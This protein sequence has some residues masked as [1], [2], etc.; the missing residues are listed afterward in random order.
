MINLSRSKILK[1]AQNFNKPAV[2]FVITKGWYLRLINKKRKGLKFRKLSRSEKSEIKDYWKQYGKNISTDWCAYFS[3]GSRIVDKRYIPESLYYGEIIRKINDQGMGGLSDKNVYDMIFDTLQ[4]RTI[5]RKVNGILLNDIREPISFE[6][7]LELCSTKRNV[8]IKPSKG[9]Y[10]G[11]GINFWS[12]DNGEDKLKEILN[13]RSDLIC[14][15]VLKQHEFFDS[16][17]PHSLNTLRI[18]TL[19][20]DDKPVHL[21]TILR[22]GSNK[23]KVDNF[24]AGGCICAVDKEGYLYGEA[25]QADQSVL[26]EHPNGFVFK[27]KK[28]PHYKEMIEDAKRMHYRIPYFKLISW[29]Y[30]LNSEGEPVLIEGNYPTGQLDMHQLNIGPIFGEYTDRVLEHV[31]KGKEL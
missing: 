25:V 4:P 28:I 21:S 14:Q 30:A 6:K 11:S 1:I 27:G 7:A 15:E 16:I 24:S 31:Y 13:S 26:T 29:D 5:F 8:I 10:G 19:L 23:S 9:T 17:H 3:Y 2:D 18:V 12:K 20:I 22:M